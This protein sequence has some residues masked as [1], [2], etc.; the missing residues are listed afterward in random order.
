MVTK[1][2]LKGRV[3]LQGAKDRSIS[4]GQE[5]ATAVIAD[6]RFQDPSN[7]GELM[8]LVRTTCD[9]EL[10]DYVSSWS[11]A[12]FRR[13][14]SR[15]TRDEYDELTAFLAKGTLQGLFRETFVQSFWDV[16]AVQIPWFFEKY[17]L[18]A[19]RRWAAHTSNNYTTVF[20]DQDGN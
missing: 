10:D 14:P 7:E 12:P 3:F 1:S 19:M 16:A 11:P 5:L 18:I 4:A 20:R 9:G 6:R 15:F 8:R 2:E 17:T 13:S